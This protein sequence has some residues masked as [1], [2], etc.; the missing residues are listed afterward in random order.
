MFC[1]LGT[2]YRKFLAPLWLIMYHLR[3][4]F[5]KTQFFYIWSL[6][7][8]SSIRPNGLCVNTPGAWECLCD[9]GYFG[10]S[11]QINFC[12]RESPCQNGGS[13]LM[14]GFGQYSCLCIDNFGGQNC[15]ISEPTGI[16]ITAVLVNGLLDRDYL[17]IFMKVF[18][19]CFYEYY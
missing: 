6:N 3:M 9:F 10:E 17:W 13:C 16:N 8:I 11:C 7:Y 1:H 5:R 15:T 12:Q 18:Q 14:Q 4:L 2:I 19:L